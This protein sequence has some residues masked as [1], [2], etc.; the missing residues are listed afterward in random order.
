MQRDRAVRIIMIVHSR[1]TTAA[2]AEV[3]ATAVTSRADSAAPVATEIGRYRIERLLGV[4]G[5]GVVYAAFDPELE[6]RVALKVLSGERGGESIGRERLL[7]EARAMARLNHPNVITVFEVG[8]AG[9][10]DYVAME[11]VD[12]SN[13]A[14]WLRTD[15][16]SRREIVASFVQAGAGLAAAHAIGLIHRD[17]K[18]HNVM[19]WRDGSV[20]VSDFGLAREVGAQ[21]PSPS[22][23]PVPRNTPTPLAELTMTGSIVGTPAYMA[24]E[25]WQGGPVGAAADQ[26]AFCVALWEALVGER[27]FRGSLDEIRA[28]ML[29]GPAELDDTRI[30]RSLRDLLRRGL[31]PDPARRWPAMVDVLRRMANYLRQRQL[32]I[33]LAG[34]IAMTVA[35][36]GFVGARGRAPIDGCAPPLLDVGLAWSP[37]RLV[38]LVARQQEPAVRAIDRDLRTWSDVRGRVCKLDVAPRAPALA[39]LD[40]VMG[41]IDAAADALAHVTESG[42]DIDGVLIDPRACEQPTPPRLVPRLGPG[43]RAVFARAWGEDENPEVLTQAVIDRL[44]AGAGDDPCGAANALLYGLRLAESRAAGRAVLARAASLAETCND[45]YVRFHVTFYEATWEFREPLSDETLRAIEHVDAAARRLGDAQA[46]ADVDGFKGARAAAEGRV[47]DLLA[48]YT[49]A[50]ERYRK[51]GA[52]GGYLIAAQ[53]VYRARTIRA[54]P[55]DVAAVPALLDEMHR[56]AS[57]GRAPDDLM[58]ANVDYLRAQWL[59]AN[60]DVAGADAIYDRWRRPS[61]IANA[62]AVHGRVVDAIGAPVAGATVTS[63]CCLEGGDALEAALP[64]RHVGSMRSQVTDRDGRFV[65][66]ESV[67]SGEIIAQLDQRRSRPRAIADDVEIVLEDTTRIEGRVAIGAAPAFDVRVTARDVSLPSTS[68]YLLGA[69]VRRDGTFVLDGVPR[70]KIR[71]AVNIEGTATSRGSSMALDVGATPVAGVEL[72][73][74]ELPRTIAVLVRSTVGEAIPRATV[75]SISGNAAPRTYK[76]LTTLTN[77]AEAATAG[78]IGD[79]ASAAVAARKQPGDLLATLHADRG[80]TSICV[81]GLPTDDSRAMDSKLA[82]AAAKIPVACVAARAGDDVVVVEVPPFPRLD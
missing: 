55:E 2:G 43:V 58:V 33:G 3:T 12:G 74:P 59:H 57:E 22:D 10:H 20:Q 63:S 38:D 29:R 15:R 11:L 56:V 21:A 13:L 46:L 41:G 40:G 37:A 76:E 8:S 68:S 44:V 61:P 16:P 80:D 27:P 6:R 82:T 24:P 67:G 72:A 71:I 26:F 17:F 32:V 53:D 35:A 30:P 25:Q 78:P 34:A 69:T 42:A 81:L 39:C 19:R 64:D 77:S 36:I 73:L 79:H 7:R 66:P 51:R 14:D 31:D 45:D 65:L 28:A 5:M 4:G 54:R 50:M 60:G 18:P 62:I 1:S 70:G 48:L 49:S 52:L 9:D 75:W 23:E 47:D